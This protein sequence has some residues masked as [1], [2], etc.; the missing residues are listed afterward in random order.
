MNRIPL[1]VAIALVAGT[2]GV[3]SAASSYAQSSV[4]PP[5]ESPVN[6]LRI[7]PLVPALGTIYEVVENGAIGGYFAVTDVGA[8]GITTAN[9]ANRTARWIMG[10]FPVRPGAG[11]DV[12]AMF[13]LRP[14]SE[15]RETVVEERIGQD[16]W[17]HHLRIRGFE[18]IWTPAGPFDAFVIED[19]ERAINPAQ[20]DYHR[21]R[22]FWYAPDVGFVVKLTSQ[23]N[24]GPPSEL[25]NWV[26]Y[27]VRAPAS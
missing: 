16:G 9:S 10:F 1:L 6:P 11:I 27:R 14:L 15:G 17:R 20:G 2:G 5:P 13:T 23:Q 19:D 18:T 25:V 7:S 8:N 26:L 21:I 24:S 3:F 12:S 22:T 4:A